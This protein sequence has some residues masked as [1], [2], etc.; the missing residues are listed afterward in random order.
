MTKKLLLF[1]P[2]RSLGGS[3]EAN[4]HLI[5]SAARGH[6]PQKDL[7]TTRAEISHRGERARPHSE[8]S[9]WWV[10][11]GTIHRGG[12]YSSSGLAIPGMGREQASAWMPG[13]DYG[14]GHTAAVPGLSVKSCVWV[15]AVISSGDLRRLAIE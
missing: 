5:I 10:G 6:E 9:V 4:W 1:V 8:M 15:L 12:G 3:S 2:T 11:D 14:F 7:Y 13:I